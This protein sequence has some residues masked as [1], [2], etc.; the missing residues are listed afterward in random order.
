MLSVSTEAEPKTLVGLGR[1]IEG[2]P[3]L[4]FDDEPLTESGRRACDAPDDEDG[5]GDNEADTRVEFLPPHLDAPDPFELLE[6][7]SSE[8]WLHAP[9]SSP[10]TDVSDLIQPHRE[11]E[12]LPA[13]WDD[14]DEEA[15]RP[16]LFLPNDP[17]EPPPSLPGNRV[18]D[19]SSPWS[20]DFGAVRPARGLH[21]RLSGMLAGAGMGAATAVA[22]VALFAWRSSGHDLSV[23]A[24]VPAPPSSDLPSEAMTTGEFSASVPEAHSQTQAGQDSAAEISSYVVSSPATAAAASDDVR[25]PLAPSERGVPRN[26]GAP[27]TAL[28]VK[29][30][31]EA[32]VSGPR[33]MLRLSS[34]PAAHVVLDGRPVGMTPKLLPVSAGEHT[35]LFVHPDL[36]RRTLRVSVEEADKVEAFARF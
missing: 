25:P 18:A 1:P 17:A 4:A 33:G 11:A 3:P 24:A 27:V 29:L 28:P 19:S 26:P 21:P 12:L 7:P 35:V 2:S 36:G 31:E 5:F 14:G 22:L 15:T 32:V 34:L 9:D 10:V 20:T 16:Q 13:N 30:E 23:P 8:D 6:R